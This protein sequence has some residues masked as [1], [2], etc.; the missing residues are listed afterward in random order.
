MTASLN[1]RL[2]LHDEDLKRQ[3]KLARLCADLQ[4]KIIT[5]LG[6]ELRWRFTEVDLSLTEA[7]A[8]D[9]QKWPSFTP[10]TVW[11]K[12]QR[13]TWFAAEVVVPE[14]AAGATLIIRFT[15]QW[16]DRPGTTDPQCL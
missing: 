5:P 6:T 8:Y 15:S 2:D 14:D 12:K 11:A 7:L 10:R 16:Q 13:H 4:Q 1:S 9:W 3:A